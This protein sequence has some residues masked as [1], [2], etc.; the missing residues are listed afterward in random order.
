MRI[1]RYIGKDENEA[2]I[3]VRNEL[4][5]DALII[6]IKKIRPSGVLGFFKKPLVEVMAGIEENYQPPEKKVIQPIKKAPA[7]VFKEEALRESKVEK[8]HEEVVELKSMV[9]TILEKMD[10]GEVTSVSDNHQERKQTKRE[11]YI[12]FLNDNDV[13]KPIAKK[14]MEI[15][16]RQISIEDSSDRT[17]LN[18]IKVIIREY[19]G[20]IKA[21]NTQDTGQQK[22]FLY[23]GPTGV[24]KTTTLAKIAARLAL[25]ENKDVAFIT[26]DTYRIAAVEQLRTYSEILGIPLEVV[27]EP[28]EL[29]DALEKFKDKDYILIDTAGRS[30]KDHE[31][32]RDILGIMDFIENPEV[33]LV[34]SMT[35]SYKDIM[36][37]VNYYSFIDA[38]RLIFTKLDEAASLGNILNIKVMTGM[39]LSYFAIGQSVP[40]DIEVADKEKVVNYIVGENHG[41]STKTS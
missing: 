16:E 33:F 36:N 30:H 13:T 11:E 8:Y 37:I 26:A 41:S 20:E 39:P 25:T 21:I 19:L 23:V 7:P 5:R 12:E 38:Y 14:I 4:G 1:K 2:M 27:Y 29:K 35:T 40:D 22:T 24:G 34:M 28:R 18:A 15:L 17:I 3:K 9:N 10:K 6:N 32:K 31:L